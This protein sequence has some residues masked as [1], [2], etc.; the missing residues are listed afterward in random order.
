[1]WLVA[2]DKLRD[3]AP[4][5]SGTVHLELDADAVSFWNSSSQQLSVVPG[6]YC[7]LV[8]GDNG[9]ERAGLELTVSA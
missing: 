1:M 7:V 2:F 3:V 5:A 6:Q 9:I 4:G 8:N